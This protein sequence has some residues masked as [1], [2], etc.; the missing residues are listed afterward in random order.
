MQH[1]VSVQEFKNNVY[2]YESA[3]FMG[4]RPTVVDLYTTWCSACKTMAPGLAALYEK[5]KDDVDVIK[6][7]VTE[8]DELCAALEIQSVPTILFFNPSEGHTK[9]MVGAL[10]SAVIEETMQGL[11]RGEEVYV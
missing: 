3:S 5:Y 2:D 11:F 7:D 10:P 9:T 6:V 1:E 8:A 4:T